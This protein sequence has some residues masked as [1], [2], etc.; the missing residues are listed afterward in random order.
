[1]SSWKSLLSCTVVG[2]LMVVQLELATAAPMPRSVGVVQAFPG[3]TTTMSPVSHCNCERRISSLARAELFR[4]ASTSGGCYGPY[5]VYAEPPYGYPP[6]SYGCSPYHTGPRSYP[7][8]A[9]PCHGYRHGCYGRHCC[10]RQYDCPD[11]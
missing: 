7:F 11:L 6:V 3:G 9:Y 4:G 2:V 8:R 5:C 10:Y 1:M